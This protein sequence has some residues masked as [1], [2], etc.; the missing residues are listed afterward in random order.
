[1]EYSWNDRGKTKYYLVIFDQLQ[2]HSGGLIQAPESCVRGPLTFTLP[3]RLL[4]LEAIVLDL[5]RV[6]KSIQRICLRV[7][8]CFR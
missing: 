1:M 5:K 6:L 3:S 8:G 7:A 2:G 4:H